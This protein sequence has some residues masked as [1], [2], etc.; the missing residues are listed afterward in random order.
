M[1]TPDGLPPDDLALANGERA[2]DSPPN[3]ITAWWGGRKEKNEI[4]NLP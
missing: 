1:A 4:V 3:G 2:L